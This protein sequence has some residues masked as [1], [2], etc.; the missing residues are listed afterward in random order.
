M[1]AS[2]HR[3]PAARAGWTPCS[4]PLGRSCMS[5]S[6]THSTV[7]ATDMPLAFRLIRAIAR[8]SGLPG[9]SL[10]SIVECVIHNLS[11]GRLRVSR[12]LCS[13]SVDSARHEHRSRQTRA[14]CVAPT[15][16][17]VPLAVWAERARGSG[18]T[19]W[20]SRLRVG[21]QSERR[22]KICSPVSATGRDGR[23]AGSLGQRPTTIRTTVRARADV[24]VEG[25]VSKRCPSRRR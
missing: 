6:A 3:Q 17:S 4:P 19:F 23:V 13:A 25:E 15:L 21:L 16:P 11:A 5:S 10:A 14:G 18:G 24:V 2:A 8:R 20:A 7:A 22:L 12:R 1:S 9:L